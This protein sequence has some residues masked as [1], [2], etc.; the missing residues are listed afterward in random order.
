VERPL[1]ALGALA[2]LLVAAPAADAHSL[3]R[4]ADGVAAYISV[5]EVSLNTLTVTPNGGR[6]DF[7]DP[8]AYQGMD[9]GT[10]DPGEVS[11]DAN[12]YVLQAFCPAAAITSVRVELGN[13]EDTA[14]VT[15]GVPSVL[16]GG[17]GADALT[18]GDTADTVDGGPGNDRIVTGG[19]ADVAIGGAGVDDIDSGAGDDDIRVRDGLRDVVRCGEGNDRTDA[20]AFDEL[21]ADCENVSR[22][23]TAPPPESGSTA[24]DKTAP[25]V[26]VGAITL[27]RLG[28]R[29]VVR[30]VGTSSER[31]TLGASGYIDI[32]G[33]RLP[34]GNVSKPVNVPGAG[35]EL[36]LKL[37]K[38]QL[39]EAKKMLKRK[40][41]V[42]VH[43]SVVATDAAGNSASKRAPRIRVSA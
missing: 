26:D 3:V 10:C 41:K 34:L 29:G 13:R 43:L 1:P 23:A 27:Q 40:R 11:N 17:D 9:I 4:V 28:K 2:A 38:A 22:T 6:I 35:A 25:K 8:T 21:A 33:L 16:L 5:D 31:G 42:T 30:V 12:A 19:A 24:T 32:A 7:H 15:P 36:T 37:T 39:R 18:T 14:T 20:D